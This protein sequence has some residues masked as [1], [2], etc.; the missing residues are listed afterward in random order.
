MTDWQDPNEMF[1]KD[2]NWIC[3]SV[4]LSVYLSIC[5]ACGC[6]AVCHSLTKWGS[7]SMKVWQWRHR[8]NLRERNA[9]RRI[10]ERGWETGRTQSDGWRNETR[11][12]EE[13][14][15]LWG[16]SVCCER[17]ATAW[18]HRH[19]RSLHQPAFH[20]RDSHLNYILICNTTILA[21]IPGYI[22][23]QAK[24]WPKSAN[25]PLWLWYEFYSA[26]QHWSMWSTAAKC[27]Q[28]NFE[29][30]DIGLWCLY[31]SLSLLY[32]WLCECLWRMESRNHVSTG[33]LTF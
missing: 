3:L 25:Q 6:L 29:G 5:Y 1:D 18:K 2:T 17:R 21:H 20:R 10:A 19:C 4:C 8:G 27:C 24:S 11:Q 30:L 13:K 9:R 31:L 28:V 22:T 14:A 15:A 7:G 23:L 16:T 33:K 26:Y 32:R 12:E